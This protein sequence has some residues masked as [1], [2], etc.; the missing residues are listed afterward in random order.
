SRNDGGQYVLKAMKVR[1]E[2]SESAVRVSMS[3]FT[4]KTEVEDFIKSLREAVMLLK[5]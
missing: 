3:R 1:E 4:T 2:I 5:F